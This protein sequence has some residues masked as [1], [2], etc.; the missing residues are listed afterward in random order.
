M[1]FR[2]R[3]RVGRGFLVDRKRASPRHFL[4]YVHAEVEALE[5]RCEIEAESGLSH[6]VGTDERDLETTAPEG[7]KWEKLA[8]GCHNGGQT[9]TAGT[10]RGQRALAVRTNCADLLLL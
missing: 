3:L 7:V 4:H 6:A 5:L 9:L 10:A 8:R 2:S 1:L